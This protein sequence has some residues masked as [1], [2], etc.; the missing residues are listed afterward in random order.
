MRRLVH[1]YAC[2][3]ACV[4]LCARAYGV[5]VGALLGRA[6]LGQAE[7]AQLLP[8]FVRA[9]RG[10]RRV[11]LALSHRPLRQPLAA[12]AGAL[13]TKRVHAP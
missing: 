2:A 5:Y 9:R 12:V 3:R 13:S 11:P 10:G 1:A 4:D 6:G 8:G 7:V